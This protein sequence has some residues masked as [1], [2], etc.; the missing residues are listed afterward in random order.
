M[1]CNDKNNILVKNNILNE[2]KYWSLLQ[3]DT[4]KINNDISIEDILKILNEHIDDETLKKNIFEYYIKYILKRTRFNQNKKIKW[5]KVPD[6]DFKNRPMVEFDNNGNWSALITFDDDN[7]FDILLF[8]IDIF[9]HE[10]MNNKR[11]VLIMK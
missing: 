3:L 7:I 6:E 1:P 10:L 9:K 4:K 11:K 2:I 5:Y 8:V